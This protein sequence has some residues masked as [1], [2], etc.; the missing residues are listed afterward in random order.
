MPIDSEK[1]KS[2][3]K[4]TGTETRLVQSLCETLD[5]AL[6]AKAIGI[7]KEHARTRLK[8]IFAKTG[9][10][11]QVELIL[12]LTQTRS[13]YGY[14]NCQSDSDRM[15]GRGAGLLSPGESQNNK[16]Q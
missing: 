14:K 10:R 15:T 4:L 6:S 2:T 3:Y 11:K 16:Y 7:T 5:L 13:E 9:T 8:Q 1:V 12:L